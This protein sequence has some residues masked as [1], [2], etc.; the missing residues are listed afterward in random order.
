MVCSTGRCL[1]S[2]FPSDLSTRSHREAGLITFQGADFSEAN[3][4]FMLMAWTLW[5]QPCPR[6]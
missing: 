2:S 3:R 4:P 6:F 5:G 1:G